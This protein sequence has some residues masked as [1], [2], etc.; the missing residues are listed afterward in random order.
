MYGLVDEHQLWNHPVVLGNG[1]KLFR[2]VGPTR[3]CGSSTAERRS[4]DS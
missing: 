1:K 2:D 3:R 4:R